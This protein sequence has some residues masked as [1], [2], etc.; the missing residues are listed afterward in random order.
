MQTRYRFKRERATDWQALVLRPTRTLDNHSPES[1]QKSIQL[2]PPCTQRYLDGPATRVRLRGCK[3]LPRKEGTL[4]RVLS[5]TRALL[6]NDRW[7][8]VPQ[9]FKVPLLCIAWKALFFAQGPIHGENKRPKESPYSS[10]QLGTDSKLQSTQGRVQC[11]ATAL[12]RHF[13]RQQTR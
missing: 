11:P 9:A 1:S 4:S 3:C 6:I 13:S 10:K 2:W 7:V 12:A 5:G 8:S